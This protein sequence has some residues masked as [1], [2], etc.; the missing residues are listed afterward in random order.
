MVSGNGFGE[1][2]WGM[3]SGNGF[4]EWFWEMVLGMVSEN[5]FGKWF[6]RMVSGNGFSTCK[7]FPHIGEF[8]R[9]V[10]VC[11]LGKG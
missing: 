9:I 6:R 3:V 1:W 7:P 10:F 8:P 5:G 4:G 11:D 2:F